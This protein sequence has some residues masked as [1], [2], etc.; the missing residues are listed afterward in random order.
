[1]QSEHHGCQQHDAHASSSK[2]HSNHTP[3][4]GDA[5][6]Q[7]LGM[8]THGRFLGDHDTT[9]ALVERQ[10]HSPQRPNTQ[11][12]GPHPRRHVVQLLAPRLAVGHG[13]RAGTLRLRTSERGPWGLGATGS[14]RLRVAVD[15]R[16]GRTS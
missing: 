13:R 16:A 7:A 5:T 1:M 15:M 11:H 3:E 14:G 6:P 12:V 8:P 10:E 4:A 9:G 2:Q